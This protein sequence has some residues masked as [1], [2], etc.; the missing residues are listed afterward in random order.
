M[1]DRH[2]GTTF[3][4]FLAEEGILDEVDA[5]A[6]KRVIAWKIAQAMQ[7]RRIPKKQLAADI[8][9]SRSQLD[10][11]LD[12]DNTSLQLTTITRAARAVGLRLVVDLKPLPRS[13]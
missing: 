12:P 5:V 13:A 3:E 10:R 8:G 6:V 11:L 7:R 4:S 1:A 9:T 2:A